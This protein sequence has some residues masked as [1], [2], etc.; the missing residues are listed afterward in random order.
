MIHLTNVP[1]DIYMSQLTQFSILIV[2]DNEAAAD[3]LGKLLAFR[4]HTTNIVH[5][6][7]SVVD[8]LSSCMPHIAL[9][10][11]GLPGISGYEVAR[12]IRKNGCPIPLIAITGYGQESDR[13][14]AFDAG[15]DHHLTKPVL[16]ADIERIFSSLE[17]SAR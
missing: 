12:K 15:F 7:E 14:K 10:D 17:L 9:I 3:V 4:G 16:L 13:Q 1:F 8:A 6:G 2:D 11:I 5:D